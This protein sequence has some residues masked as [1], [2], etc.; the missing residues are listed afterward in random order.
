MSELIL[1][2]YQSIPLLFGAILLI[3]LL[4][5]GLRITGKSTKKTIRTFK[6]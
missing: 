6:K 5:F 4:N 2:A 3:V 1:N